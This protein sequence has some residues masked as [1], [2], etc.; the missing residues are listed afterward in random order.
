MSSLIHSVIGFSDSLYSTKDIASNFSSQYALE[1][2][3]LSESPSKNKPNMQ[4]SKTG[5][6]DP[7]YMMGLCVY[8]VITVSSNF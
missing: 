3:G 1:L 2:A 6:I 5:L 4:L 7:S 8:R